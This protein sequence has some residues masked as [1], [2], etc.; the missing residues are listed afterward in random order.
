MKIPHILCLGI[1]AA[2]WGGAAFAQ[3]PAEL[4]ELDDI[5]VTGTRTEK[6]LKDS[7][8]LTE[9]ITAK[10]IENSSATTVTEILDDY[11][12]MVSGGP[13]GDDIQLQGMGEGRVLYLVDGRRV[14]G[15]INQKLDGDTMP[16][17]NVERIEIVRGPQSALY[18]SDGIGGVVN[19]ITKKPEDNFTFEAALSN[20]F[21][22]AHDNPDTAKKPNAFDDFNPI[23]EQHL[24]ASIGIPIAVTRNTITLEASRGAFYL[25]EDKSASLA[26]EYYRGKFGLD[27]AFP[28]GDSAEMALGGSVMAMRS[29]EQTSR[30][31]SL[32][33]REYVRAGGYAEAKLAPWS[34]YLTLR[35]YDDFY[36]RDMDTYSAI[37]ETWT[38]GKN[39]EYENLIAFEAMGSYDGIDHFIFTSGLEGAYNSMDKYNLKNRGSTFVWTDREALYLQAEYYQEDQYSFILGAR[40]ERSSQF[41]FGGAPKFSAMVHLSKGFRLLGGAGLGYRAPSFSDLYVTMDD[42]VVAGNPLVMGNEDLKPEYALSFNLALEYAKEGLCFAQINGYYT[43]LWNEIVY[44]DMGIISG[45]LSYRNG[46]VARSMR[47]G[48]DSEGRLTVFKNVFVSAGYSWLYA[49]DRTEEE[50]FYPQSAHT[51]KGKLGWDYKKAGIHTYLQGRYF[52]PLDPGDDS[53]DHRFILDFYFALSFADHVT[54]HASVDNITGLID[55][56][57]PTV[58]RKFTL[59]LKYVL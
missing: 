22:L 31:G 13:M 47:T 38:T 54:V 42:T 45:S 2:A 5:T 39:H 51:V 24:T 14:T 48:F 59:G 46:N 16:L 6:R 12:L 15:R 40:G 10:E 3:E 17:S 53:Y 20:T 49:Y 11:G 28:A 8:V 41:G 25:N 18:G 29:D 26:P 1:L 57:G 33:R 19:I 56:L 37:T 58:G 23:R 21:L 35:L 55:S 36:Q 32:T 52:S 43:E 4:Y 34:G 50:R 30:L 9:V 7:P 44:Q 27:T